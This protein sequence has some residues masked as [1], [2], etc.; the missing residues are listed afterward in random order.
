MVK[1]DFWI[2]GYRKIFLP[3]EKLGPLAGILLRAG[4]PSSINPDGTLSVREKYIE[5]VRGLFF[6]KTEYS[7]SEP[8][9]FV[10]FFLRLRHKKSCFFAALI[11]LLLMILSNSLVW[12]VRIEG[13]KRIP[14]SKIANELGECGLN[15]GDLFFFVDR[16]EVEARLLKKY[17]DISWI[18]INRRGSVAY[19]TVIEREENED[20][21]EKE[22]TG[23]SN[24]VAAYDCVIEEISVKRGYAAV[25][26][27]QTVKRGDLLISG[28]VPG[29]L[30]D[31]FCYAE[32]SVIGRVNETVNAECKR[33]YLKK[34]VKDDSIVGLDINFFDFSINIFKN[35]RKN[36]KEYVIIKDVKTFSLLGKRKLPFETVSE[37]CVEYEYER[38]VYTDSEL[39]KKTSA[40]LNAL[41][42]ARLSEC[43]L[44][45]LKTVGEFTEDGYRMSSHIVFLTDVGKD[46]PFYGE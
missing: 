9:G 45:R 28:V 37:R 30:G 6:G 40:R 11:S 5:R 29:E 4:I 26:V 10:G 17:P 41:T 3:K 35:Y 15:V 19:V 21:E 44:L 25:K 13:N 8:L 16:G 12:D 42:S 2:F 33:E 18:N 27:G 24:I 23:Y 36:N 32:G 20:S 14:D 31:T 34:S 1:I 22:K 46:L 38:G 43:D 39:V 7:I